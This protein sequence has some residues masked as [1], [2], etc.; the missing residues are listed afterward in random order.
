VA[1]IDDNLLYTFK[2]TTAGCLRSLRHAHSTYISRSVRIFTFKNPVQ[3]LQ[4]HEAW[5]FSVNQC[6]HCSGWTINSYINE[7]NIYL[8]MIEWVSVIASIFT[9]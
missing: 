5:V 8:L 3:T 7:L 4:L 2:A 6:T 9:F 1:N